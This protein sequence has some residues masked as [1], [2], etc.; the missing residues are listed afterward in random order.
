MQNCKTHFFVLLYAMEMLLLPWRCSCC[1][2]DAFVAMEMLLLPWR[3]SCCHDVSL[4][5]P[6]KWHSE[7]T[8]T[9]CFTDAFSAFEK[10]NCKYQ[11]F[12]ALQ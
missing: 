6:H 7:I 3:C 8:V 11:T 9:L 4:W 10:R 5:H 12:P 2:G 1:H